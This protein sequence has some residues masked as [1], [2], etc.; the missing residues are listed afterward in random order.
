MKTRQWIPPLSGSLLAMGLLLSANGLW[1]SDCA[2]GMQATDAREMRAK[3]GWGHKEGGL[4]MLE[5]LQLGEEQRERLRQLLREQRG[6]GEHRSRRGMDQEARQRMRALIEAETYD[7]EA[8]EAFARE[9]GERRAAKVKL[10]IETG[11]KIQQL[12]SPEQ[13]SELAQLREEERA[14]HADRDG[15]R[16]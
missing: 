3:H 10:R 8:V 14:R 15:D 1:A 11:W 2:E 16:D 9:Q 4:R 12:L 13:R 7:A 6:E 5:Q